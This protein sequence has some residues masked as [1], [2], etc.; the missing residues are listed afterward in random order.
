MM[1]S[2][3]NQTTATVEKKITGDGRQNRHKTNIYMMLLEA[4]QPTGHLKNGD[5]KTNTQRKTLKRI[6]A[7][8]ISIPA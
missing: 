8:G 5:T 2:F 3:H 1:T 6:F 7:K 4:T